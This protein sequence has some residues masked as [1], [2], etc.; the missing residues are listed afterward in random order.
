MIAAAAV[1]FTHKKF[2]LPTL[3]AQPWKHGL[4]SQKKSALI[5]LQ[6]EH[7]FGTVF[8]STYCHQTSHKEFIDPDSGKTTWTILCYFVKHYIMMRIFRLVLSVT[9]VFW[10]QEKE[11]SF[12]TEFWKTNLRVRKQQDSFLRD[13][14]ILHK[15]LHR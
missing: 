11:V 10:T 12:K 7:S 2:C 8:H 14:F 3:D 9:P 15:I 1:L 13:S 4:I 6:I 5:I